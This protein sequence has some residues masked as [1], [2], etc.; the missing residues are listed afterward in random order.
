MTIPQIAKGIPNANLNMAV[1]STGSRPIRIFVGIRS[2]SLI[3]NLPVEDNSID[4]IISN[5]VINLTPNKKKVFKEAYRVLKPGG[6]LMVSDV[7][8]TKPLPEDLKNDKELLIGCISGAILKKDY[9]TLLKQTGF[10]DITIHK[11]QPAFLEDYGLSITYSA[12]K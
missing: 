6:K 3:E 2:N 5:C 8:L 7:V 12:L 1:F 10:S 4:T 11:E 9:L